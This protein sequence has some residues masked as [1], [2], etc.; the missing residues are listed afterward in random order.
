M[1]K[2]KGYVVE[3]F[4]LDSDFQSWVRYAAPDKNA[5]WAHYKQEN[6]GQTDDIHRARL[7]LSIVYSR[8]DTTISEA[9]IEDEIS[10]LVQRIRNGQ[11]TSVAAAD[12][13]TYRLVLRWLAAAMIVIA[14]GWAVWL[15]LPDA[16]KNEPAGPVAGKTLVEQT[17]RTTSSQTLVLEDSSLVVLEPG[18]QLRMPPHFE[19]D[20]REVLLTGEAFFKIRKDVKRPFLVRS[21]KLITRVLGTSFTVKAIKGSGEEVVEVKEGKV[22]VYKTADFSESGST[23]ESHG[24]VV[25]SNQKVTF[26][27]RE[28]RLVKTLSNTPEMMP[29]KARLFRSGY[30]NTPVSEVLKDLR[31][32]YQVDIIFDEELLAG[33]PLTATLSDQSLK[34]KL[35]II[36]EAI[37]AQYEIL[38]G[39]IMI[40]GK[41]CNEY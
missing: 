18:A 21:E 20:K 1:N 11:E 27:S 25:T 3:D 7:L 38:D 33:C 9:E 37:E 19:A 23:R 8:Y 40:Y 4:V 10:A 34:E 12:S 22:S 26:E 24:L 30:V 5:F 29:D 41:S 6:P 32:A 2:Y 13:P 16:G 39:Q 15:L 31:N 35:A 28:G 17:N 14:G 36:C